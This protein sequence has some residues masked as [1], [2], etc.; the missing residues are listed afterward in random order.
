[1]IIGQFD[2]MQLRQFLPQRADHRHAGEI[3]PPPDVLVCLRRAFQHRQFQRGGQRAAFRR[4]TVSQQAQFPREG[5]GH[6]R[7]HVLEMP[8][9]EDHGDDQLN[10][11]DRQHEDQRRPPVQSAGHISFE[12][13][14]VHRYGAPDPLPPIP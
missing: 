6:L 13:V 1:M 3:V 2:G 8:L 11:H 4:G 9:D 7:G 10:H 14:E 12:P 5:P